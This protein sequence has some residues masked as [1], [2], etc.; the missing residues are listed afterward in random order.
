MSENKAG[1]NDGPTP[2]GASG[3]WVNI[4]LRFDAGWEIQLPDKKRI[5]FPAGGGVGGPVEADGGTGGVVIEPLTLTGLDP[6]ATQAAI[7]RQARVLAMAAQALGL[8]SL[9]FQD[10]LASQQ[11]G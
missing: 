11:A 1:L 6:A 4:S 10:A 8:A 2:S 5:G 7:A 9:Q 3:G